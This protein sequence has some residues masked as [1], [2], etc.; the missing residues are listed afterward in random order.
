MKDRLGRSFQLAEPPRR[1]AAST[2][3]AV[4]LGH[5]LA[6]WGW[7]VVALGMVVVWL[8]AVNAD[9]VSLYFDRLPTKRVTGVVTSVEPTGF[10]EGGGKHRRGRPIDAISFEFE[11]DG[12]KWAGRSYLTQPHQR[13]AGKTCH[14][15]YPAGMPQH[16]RV[17]GARR[18]VFGW[19][20]A[21]GV[22][23]PLIGVGLF[24]AGLWRGIRAVGFLRRGK[25]ALAR[26]V[27]KRGL[28]QHV[29]KKQV[30]EL[31]FAFR[32]D[33]DVE[34][35]FKVRTA[36]VEPLSD[37]AEER[38]LYDP[39]RPS[40]AATVDTL[41]GRPTIEEGGE[42]GRVRAWHAWAAVGWP[43]LVVAGHAWYG[44]YRYA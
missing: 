28:N 1:V 18:A 32:T 10:S 44:W 12:G 37:D 40:R 21:L 16:A 38:I 14:L 31:T 36:D 17:Q 27:R 25:P 39:A 23:V 29:N 30:F 22:V 3:V 4:A 35:E 19:P 20:A 7:L 5:P 15:D 26:L 34:Q 9:V 11:L 2:A 13:S 24:G 41:P 33:E 6:T 42:I 43:L 8:F